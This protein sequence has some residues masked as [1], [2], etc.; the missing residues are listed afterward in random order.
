MNLFFLDIEPSFIARFLCDKHIQQQG[1]ELLQMMASNWPEHFSTGDAPIGGGYPHHQMTEWVKA[2]K[3]NYQFCLELLEAIIANCRLRGYITEYLQQGLLKAR[4]L[5]NASLQHISNELTDI[6]LC[7]PRSLFLPTQF[8]P[9]QLANIDG[10][11]DRTDELKPGSTFSGFWA[12]SLEAAVIAYRMYYIAH[13]SS[14]AQWA[15]CEAPGWWPGNSEPY[16]VFPGGALFCRINKATNWQ[17]HYKQLLE[18]RHAEASLTDWAVLIT[19]ITPVA[20]P[21]TTR[22]S[23][24]KAPRPE[25]LV[26]LDK[27]MHDILLTP[28]KL[29]R[30]AKKK[31][32][33]DEMALAYRHLAY[34]WKHK[35][36]LFFDNAETELRKHGIID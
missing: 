17:E 8:G 35:P 14:F 6:P 24:S 15:H 22:K 19:N 23:A 20:K 10:I 9:S 28:I 36:S 33:G 26:F 29:K 18:E 34:W 12:T 1:R 7:M 5:P 21:K 2:N 16:N 25:A 13:K 31:T 3:A 4:Q 32:E 30:E 27:F 11:V